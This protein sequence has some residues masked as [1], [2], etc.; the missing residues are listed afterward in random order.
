MDAPLSRR[1]L[2]R[3][4]AAAV[5]ALLL[6][7]PLAAGSRRDPDQSRL[8]TWASALRAGGLARPEVPLG[9]AAIRV[10]ELAAGTPY[11]PYTL[12]AY[13]RAGGSP[14]RTEPLTL[15]LTRFDCVTLV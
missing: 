5:A 11:R 15:S 12:E 14:S 8:V 3:N 6:P 1:D 4:A 13:L 10:G 2:L 7:G 9:R